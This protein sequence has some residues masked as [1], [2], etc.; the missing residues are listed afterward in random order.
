MSSSV[1]AS[2]GSDRRIR[3]GRRRRP[4]GLRLVALLSS[5]T[6]AALCWTAASAQADAIIDNGTV[7]LGVHDL[8]HLNVPGGSP[9]SGGTTAVGLR[10]IPTN[11]E[12]TAPGCLCEGWGAADA[13]SGVTGFANESSGTSANLSVV[14]F[15]SDASSAVSVVD[16]LDGSANP[17]LRVTQDYHPS[18]ATPNLYEVT[19]NIENVSSSPVDARYRRVMDWDVEPTAFNEFVTIQG[20]T[21][22]ALLFDSNDG[23]D[24][25][26]PLAGPSD[27]GFT[28]NFTDAGPADHGALFDFGFGTVNPGESK[29]FRI[30]Y[31]AGGDESSALAALG[32]VGAEVYSFGQPNTPDGPTL[33]TPNTFIFAFAG[34]GGTPI[35]GGPTPPPPPQQ[36]VPA[37][38]A[39][40]ARSCGGKQATIIGT[41]Q[42][43]TLIGTKGKDVVV[44]LG[45]N[46]VLKGLSGNDFLC[47][48]RGKDNLR[49]GVGGDTLIGG[50]GPD[51]L[52]GGP[53]N[54]HLFGG[55]PKAPPAK[56]ID[57]CKGNG[58]TKRNCERVG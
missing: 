57:T 21:S 46:D 22:T 18:A 54:D 2:R 35:V 37:T 56:A 36:A 12:A 38:P 32:A 45:G 14:S 30:F 1:R 4:R 44:G 11:A 8:G 48:G 3:F 28:G 47:G 52:D 16:I 58:D 24:T 43:E 5:L 23:F 33:G 20:G 17:V 13:T 49:G 55:T 9:S 40:K 10:Y 41:G 39:K 6:L 50:A 34:V 51:S 26:D 15:T 19:V 27:I 42:P 31:G 29:S 53:S 25:A 7:Q